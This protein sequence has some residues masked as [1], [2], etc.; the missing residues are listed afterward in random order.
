ML[1]SASNYGDITRYFLHTYVKFKET[2]DTLYYI[3]RVLENKVSGRSETGD[4]FEM[5]LD[6]EHPYEME[7]VL[8]RKSVFQFGDTAVVLSRMPQKQYHRGI[9]QHNTLIYTFNRTGNP[10]PDDITFDYLRAYV[11][12]QVFF[13]LGEAILRRDLTSC[14]LSPRMLYHR[15]THQLFVDVVPIADIRT[16]TK[17]IHLRQPVFRE[18]VLELLKINRQHFPND[19]WIL[20]SLP[21]PVTVKPKKKVK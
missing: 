14:A 10:Q 13:P 21:P 20:T 1:F 16:A 12:K 19:E 15:P 6:D 2:G 18:E 7:F 11:N 17:T 4:L 5:Y 3:E 9:S 8:P